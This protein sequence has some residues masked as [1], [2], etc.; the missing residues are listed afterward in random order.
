[1]LIPLM[2]LISL[3]IQAPSPDWL[4][5][6][7]KKH[8]TVKLDARNGE[9][10]IQNGLAKRTFVLKP[11]AACIAFDNLSTGEGML[12]GVKPE[13]TVTLNGKRF[14]VG[15]LKGQPDY[16]YLN[17]GWL[18]QM[19]A[20]PAAF[21]FEGYTVGKTVARFPWK[22]KRY[23]EKLAWPPAGASLTLRFRPPDSAGL[24]GLTV[25]VHYEMYDDIPAM[26]KWLTVENGTDRPVLLN[27][28][29]SELLA[30]VERENA[31]ENTSALH[32]A[33]IHVQS[34]YAFCGGT[35]KTSD[36]TTRW[37]PDPDFTTQIDYDRQSPCLLTSSP[38]IGPAAEISPG[39]S[40]ETYREFELLLDS[41]D[42]ERRGLEIRRLQRM[43]APWSAENPIIMHL[44]ASDSASIRNAVDQC[45]AVGFEMII[46]SF[47]SGFNME[48]Q[49]SAYLAR[50]KADVDYAHRKGIEVG[51]YT[52]TGS[53]DA[54]PGNNVVAQDVIN[55][56]TGKKG[57]VFGQSPCL[58][59]AWSDGYYSRLLNF[60]K[61]TGISVIEDDGSYPGDLCASTAHAHHR[62][63]N[64]SQWAQW[65][66]IT[67]F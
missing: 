52:L 2:T 29:Q 51:G 37:L 56:K 27:A 58:A 24:R 3:P 57:A 31:V 18:K 13:A 49:D 38:P 21:Q 12:R 14:D 20:D 48:S 44:T 9:L 36:E 64:D 40:F 59:S 39:G 50:V 53:R 63:L 45:A 28:F 11:N 1:M 62:G 34:D 23:C 16:A 66:T 17:P 25:S 5:A 35:I 10:S 8:T 43:M 33:W 15:G 22:P 4:V 65:R 67:G 55:P 46:L 32:H 26:C 30:V 42:R 7:V 47:G 19:T 54:G 60:F 61:Q 6:P 41:D